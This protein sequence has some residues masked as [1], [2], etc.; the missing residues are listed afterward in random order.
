MK[1]IHQCRLC[2][3]SKIEKILDF[4]ESPLA[5]SYLTTQNEIEPKYPLT[6]SKCADCGHVQL[7][8]TI[9]PK[10]LFSS[11]SYAS[12]DSPALVAHF[13][14]YA[15]DIVSTIH[16]DDFC[17]ILEIG[18]NDGILLKQFEKLHLIYL[19]GVEPAKNLSKIAKNKTGAKIIN[20]FFNLSLSKKLYKEFGK[21]DVIC[22]NNTFAHIAD[23]DSVMKGIQHLLSKDGIFVFE[24][25]YLLD[26]VKNLY[27]DQ[28]YHEHLQYY[29]IKPLIQYLSKYHM[30]I[31]D[32]KFNNIQGGSFRIFTK[33]KSNKKI[34]I[35]ASVNLAILKEDSN[36]L[37]D[38]KTYQE[39][40]H[41]INTLNL[42]I[43]LFISQG[44]CQK[45]TFCCYGCPAK[46]TLFS[47]M[48]N[49]NKS[50]INYVVDDS[51]LKQG[52]FAPGSRIPIVSNQY[53]KD[54]LT[55]YCIISAWNMAQGIIKR[56]P[57]YKGTFIIPM[58]EIKFV[59]N[60]QSI[61]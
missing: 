25:A 38:K 60:D 23:L 31:F 34:P 49:L 56:N 58:P 26:T 10:I 30:E 43:K 16:A 29:G 15:K 36:K 4:G 20:D 47:K 1:I 46:F 44:H 54:N 11:Y 2:K 22:C 6:V 17:Q 27:F 61:I 32:V 59:R 24:N 8:E 40:D 52:K 35:N 48:F 3:S 28:I 39:F 13:E 51:P 9:D 12:S 55:D 33:M 14:E 41:K 45:K 19:V 18:C 7:N 53:F 37:Y 42:Q 57:E 5:N 50:N 21:F